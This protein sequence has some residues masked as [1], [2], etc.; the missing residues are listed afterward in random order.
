M[1]KSIECLFLLLCLSVF[2]EAQTLPKRGAAKNFYQDQATKIK[3]ANLLK[4]MTLEEKIGQLVLFAGKGMITGPSESQNMDEYV[5][6]GL[7][8]N[9][10]GTKTLA[11]AIRI[12][13]LAMEK[14]RMKIPVL[15]GLDVIHGFKTIFPTNLGIS[16]SWDIPEIEK[17]AQVSATEASAAG[18]MW[19]YSPMCDISYD[20]RWGRV[21]EGSGEDPFLG[22]CI[23]AAM[24]RGYQGKNL[25]APNSIMACVKHFA[26]YGAVQAG[27]DYNT[28]DMSERA[29]RDYY[30][31]PYRS[32]VDAGAATVMTSFNEYD[33]VPA[34]GNKFLM[35]KLL[36]KELGFNGFI[37]TDFSAINEMVP[38][39]IAKDE[40]SAAELAINA[41]VNMDM[42]GNTYLLHLK[43]LVQTGKVS[44]SAINKLC[45]E[46]LGMK[47]RLGL[48]DDPYRYFNEE[49]FKTAFYKP[50][51][52]DACRSLARKSMVLL[53]NNNNLLPIPLNKKIALIG[54]F[55][56]NQREMLGSWA[57]SG[58]A[59]HAV[60]FLSGLQKRYPTITYT[61]GCKFTS[62]IPNGFEYA[63]KAAE[64]SDVVLLTLGLP[65][66]W[67]G[68]AASL[69]S[70]Q[71]PDIQ[72]RLLEKL[73]QTGK[74]IIILLVTA[75]PMDLSR[76]IKLADAVLLTWQP[77]TMAGEALADIVTGDFNPSGKLTMTF[78]LTVG[79][80][81]IHYNVKNTG[82][83]E[84]ILGTK[85]SNKYTSRYLFTPNNPLYPFGY[86]LSYTTFDY[87]DI[88]VEGNPI[89]IGD[90]LKVSAT[91]TNT[92]LKDGDEIAQLYIRDLVGSVT[93]PVRELKGFQKVHL[94]AGESKRLVFNIT[95]DNLSFCR[96]DMSF[97]EER[98]NYHVWIGGDSNATL[99]SSFIVR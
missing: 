61:Q 9:V 42:V 26:A 78:P 72:Y 6:K 10:F 68:E 18:V 86:G 34:T 19:T 92:G 17:F 98:G 77:G 50:E 84:G 93:R 27:R 33:G 39:G 48:F 67:S 32:A 87:H 82:R 38:H 60:A 35:K 88:S 14:S 58:E 56:D 13:K 23:S 74:P 5:V 94:H 81:P 62:E 85:S 73:K 36:R 52:L 29:F 41:G 90:R 70:L 21:S 43:K 76:E 25:A 99:E 79:Q 53:Q 51:A 49:R 83:P 31:P 16:S 47:Y 89:K 22:S 96:G 30:L 8:G 28:V 44:M 95:P 80:V 66:E 11:D 37:V 69:T 46:V 24:V 1:K 55:A 2:S 40:T 91:V 57:I 7:C 59:K 12:Q 4:K 71:I 54:P 63:V 65:Y 20:P 97:G 64:Q 3:V 15:F 45:G 75:R